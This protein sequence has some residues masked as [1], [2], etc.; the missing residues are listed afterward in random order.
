MYSWLSQSLSLSLS[1][2]LC[3]RANRPT[4]CTALNTPFSGVCLVADTLLNSLRLDECIYLVS[5]AHRATRMPHIFAQT[6]ADNAQNCN[7]NR[8]THWSTDTRKTTRKRTH[9]L[10]VLLM[11]VL[12]A[13]ATTPNTKYI[14]EPLKRP[15]HW[16]VILHRSPI[17]NWLE[18]ASM[19]PN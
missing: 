16:G 17:E 19:R 18:R 14:T 8:K 13:K 12:Q 6:L 2:S 9:G 11:N 3:C 15:R 7:T 1:L 4:L 5:V 10:F